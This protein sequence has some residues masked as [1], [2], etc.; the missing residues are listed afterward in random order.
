MTSFPSAAVVIAMVV[1]VIGTFAMRASFVSIADRL[2]VLPD[3]VR[4]ILRMVPAAA[5]AALTLP[6]L[7]R[8]GGVW[9]PFGPRAIAGIIAGIVA[10][11]TRSA[12]LTVIVGLVAVAVLQPLLG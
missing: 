6:A 10:W 1:I 12:L 3:D 9:D 8:P 2:M 11:R 5:M 4:V 7:L